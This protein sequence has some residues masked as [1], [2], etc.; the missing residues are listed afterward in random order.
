MTSGTS[1]PKKCE[2]LS[3]I[4][5]YY[6]DEEEYLDFADYNDLGLPLAYLVHNNLVKLQ[7]KAESLIE[8]TWDYLLGHHGYE[9]DTGFDSFEEM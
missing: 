7:G 1:F 3:F 5:S 2:I 8:E 6:R 9:E 4:W